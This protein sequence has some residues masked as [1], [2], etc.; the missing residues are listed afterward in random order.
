MK[1]KLSISRAW[2]ET[3]SRVATDGK[4][5]LTVAFALIAL[6]SAIVQFAYPR[7]GVGASPQSILEALLVF[8]V[9]IIGIVGQLALIRLAIGPSL[10]VGDAIRHGARRTLPYLGAAILLI[11]GLFVMALPVGL[12]LAALGMTIEPS[13]GGMPPA[14]WLIVLL[15][16]ALL[17]Y[18]AARLLLISAVASAEPVGP[19]AMIK[20]SWSLTE[21]NAGR[22][23]G[24]LFLLIIAALV[25]VGAL[26]LVTNLAITLAFGQPDPL[27][28]SAL[29]IALVAAIANAAV[30]T[31]FVVMLAR[32]YVQLS[33][34]DLVTPSVPSS[35]T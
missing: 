4:L 1:S 32:F 18:F 27:S 33:G 21:G 2:E 28:V 23:L 29:V 3:R 12:A 25:V 22:L 15:F 16:L 13:A 31:L 14:G 19:L 34:E 9:T 11:I 10:T 26:T 8:I 30:T 17:L 35:G 6:P 7:E 5:L 20:R 24:F